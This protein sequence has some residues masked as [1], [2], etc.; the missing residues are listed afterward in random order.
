MVTWVARPTTQ[1][2]LASPKTC[3]VVARSEEDY[4]DSRDREPPR[5]MDQGEDD[6]LVARHPI[7]EAVALDEHLTTARGP[8]ASERPAALGQCRERT[9]PGADLG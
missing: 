7:D 6:H 9:R 5:T 8:L 2:R 1:T 3:G 4:Q